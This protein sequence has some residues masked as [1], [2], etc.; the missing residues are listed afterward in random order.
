MCLPLAAAAPVLA[1]ASGVVQGAGQLY[2]GAAQKSQ[3]KYEAQVAKQNA[4]LEIEA[5]HDS[6]QQG[7][8]EARDFWRDV[9]ATKGQ[10]IASMA[11]N[12]ID[13]SY[14][15][16]ARL[17][18][19]TQLMANDKAAT[20]YKNSQQRTRG[21]YINANN[22]VSEAKAARSRGKA[23]MTGAIFSAA[24]SILGGAT[25]GFGMTGKAK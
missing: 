2:Q 1:I 5:A 23:A 25:Q 6:V 17:Q 10:Q 24:G 3:A 21:H 22:Y 9:S 20:L 8:D 7:Q 14:G 18:D 16:G 4:Q 13:V 19:D 12:G 15:S 11:A